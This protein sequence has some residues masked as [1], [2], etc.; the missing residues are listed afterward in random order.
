MSE[1]NESKSIQFDQAEFGA[2]ESA[3]Q[4]EGVICESCGVPIGGE[5]YTLGSLVHCARCH[6]GIQSLIASGPGV[7]GFFRALGLGLLAAGA[8][9][10]GWGLVTQLTGYEIGLIAVAVGWLVGGAVRLGSRGLGGVPFQV[11]A[12]VLTYLAIVSTYVPAIL[13]AFESE[14]AMLAAEASGSETADAVAIDQGALVE[15]EMLA[16]KPLVVAQGD[17]LADE[18]AGDAAQQGELED[19]E[20]AIVLEGPGPVVVAFVIAM[21]LPFMMGFDNAIGILIIGIALFE[22]WRQN[23]RANPELAGPFRVGADTPA[24]SM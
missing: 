8:G 5:Y 4:A 16:E 3:T 21:A 1:A 18:F 2:E 7:G 23:R 10:L 19:I 24:P 13:E 6:S 12:V 17:P 22:A 14:Q 20:G 9:A 15:N 11:L